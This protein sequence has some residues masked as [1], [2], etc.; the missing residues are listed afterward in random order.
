MTAVI[1]D[2]H[3]G[4]YRLDPVPSDKEL[5]TYYESRYY[6]LIRKGGRA[7]ELRR[8]SEGGSVAQREL[9]WLREGLYR[10]I[11]E[12]LKEIA[13]EKS[14]VLDIGAGMGD[15]VRFMRDAGHDAAGIEPAKEPSE[16]ARKQGLPIHTATLSSWALDPSNE[17]TADV[18]VML[19]VLEH[20]PEPTLMLEQTRALLSPGGLVVIRVPNDFSEIQ[21]AAQRQLGKEPWWICAPDHINYFSVQSLQ[22]FLEKC[23]MQ[24]VFAMTDFPMEFF[25]LMGDD[26]TGDP[27]VGAAVHARRVKF[28]LALPSPLRRKLYAAMASVGIGRN[29]MAFAKKT[30]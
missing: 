17:G 8:L 4:Y 6:D 7:P 11:A 21:D 19:N 29:V 26:Y 15:F 20:V 25:L 30:D 16:A 13:P 23:G 9:E 22:N 1:K 18:V 24:T 14:R 5:T 12:T 10:D 3:G 27:A 2:E 28:E